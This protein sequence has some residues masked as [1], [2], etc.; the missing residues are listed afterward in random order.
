MQ[1]FARIQKPRLQSLGV[2]LS[3]WG[4]G[5]T[6]GFFTVGLKEFGFFGVSGLKASL[7]LRV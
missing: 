5:G 7:E 4:F 2:G 3:V 1:G 6:Q